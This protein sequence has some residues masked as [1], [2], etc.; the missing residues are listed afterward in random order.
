MQTS[1]SQQIEAIRTLAA[2]SERNYEALKTV[3]Q[4]TLIELENAASPGQ[5]EHVPFFKRKICVAL[6]LDLEEMAGW[7]SSNTSSLDGL[8]A[9]IEHVEMTPLRSLV[10]RTFK[11]A[12]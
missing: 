11:G 6:S 1:E 4:G 9:A 12:R 7:C 2:N 3:I 5:R 10:G 8:R